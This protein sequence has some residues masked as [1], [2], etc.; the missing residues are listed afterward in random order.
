MTLYKGGRKM[1]KT[2]KQML[3]NLEYDTSRPVKMLKSST[4]EYYKQD[5]SR[6]IRLHNTDILTFFPDGSCQ[7]NS[8]GW[9]TVTTKSR[10][11]EYG[12]SGVRID[13]EKG[14]WY[15]F[16]GNISHPFFDGIIWT[17][18]GIRH[19]RHMVEELSRVK[20]YTKLINEYV[21]EIKKLKELPL[22]SPG[23]CW[24]CMTGGSNTDHLINHLEEKYIHGTLIY[25]ALK[26]RGYQY[27]EIFFQRANP[28]AVIQGRP[29]SAS[30]IHAVRNYFKS[31]LGIAR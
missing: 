9:R 30:V 10:M 21:D 3:E 16:D 15:I 18:E 13:Q 17:P 29:I 19:D 7:F 22:P 26:D 25:N 20:H 8:G 14:M 28:A 5:G 6:V 23:D 24:I 31:K 27:P 4:L 1:K 12:P 11:N 2:K